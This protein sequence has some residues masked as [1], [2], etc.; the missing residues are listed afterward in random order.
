MIEPAPLEYWM[1]AQTKNN[2]MYFLSRYR[3]THGAVWSTQYSK[4]MKFDTKEYANQYRETY[5]TN[6]DDVYIA[7]QIVS[8]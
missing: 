7:R 6:N 4:A 5:F 2:K 1:I 8:F 3:V